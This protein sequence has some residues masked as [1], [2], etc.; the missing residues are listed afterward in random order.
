MRNRLFTFDTS[1]HALEY[2]THLLAHGVAF[3]VAP[4]ADCVEVTT[5]HHLDPADFPDPGWLR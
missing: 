5:P 4:R 3:A 1:G 2:I